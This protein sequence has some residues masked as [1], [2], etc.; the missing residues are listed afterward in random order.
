MIMVAI[1]KLQPAILNSG[2]LQS[3][4]PDRFFNSD[5]HRFKDQHQETLGLYSKGEAES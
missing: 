5:G 1:Y 4:R 3:A 2:W